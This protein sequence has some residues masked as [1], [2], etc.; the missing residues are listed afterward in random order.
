MGTSLSHAKRTFEH[1]PR[2]AKPWDLA[3]CIALP[4]CIV[5]VA[6]LFTAPRLVDWYA[7]LQKPF[8]NP[9][10]WLFGPI[11]LLMYVLIGSSLYLMYRTEGDDRRGKATVLFCLVLLLNTIW[12][13]TFFGVH[14]LRAASV[15]VVLLLLASIAT[16][17]YFYRIRVWAAYFFIPYTCWVAFTT[18]LTLTFSMIN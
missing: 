2:P 8:F 10:D 1:L 7:N 5:I 13:I 15:S 16:T 9:P 18:A 11:W 14:D 6:N 4:L 3:A 17:Y 12:S